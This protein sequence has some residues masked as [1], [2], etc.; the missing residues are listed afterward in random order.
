MRAQTDQTSPDETIPLKPTRSCDIVM[1]G[2]V[3]S[4]IVYPLTV[5]ELAR[6]YRFVNVGGASAGAI[7]ASLTAA[8]EYRRRNGDAR[9]FS[10]DLMNLPGLLGSSQ[11]GGKSLLFSLF[12]PTA[13]TRATYDCLIGFLETKSLIGKSLWGLRGLFRMAP[14]AAA[15]GSILWLLG[16]FAMWTVS[17]GW[18]FPLA[19]PMLLLVSLL[20]VAVTA[21]VVISCV[22]Q[23]ASAIVK[24][25]Y[26][27]CS[28]FIPNRKD[29]TPKPLTEWLADYLDEVAG[30]PDQ[31]AP[32]T[33]GDLWNLQPQA[34]DPSQTKSINLQMMTTNL[35]L[36]RP[37]QLPFEQADFFFSPEEFRSLFPR[38]IVDW[39]VAH[40][41][42]AGVSGYRSLPDSKH[43]PVVVATRM[44]LSFP[45]LVSAIPLYAVD[46]SHKKNEETTEKG[47]LERC[48]LSDG[49]ICS[50]FPVHFFDSPI[51]RWPTFAINLRPF[52]PDSPRDSNERKNVWMPRTNGEGVLEQWTRFHSP[53]GPGSLLE[54]LWAIID[55]MQNWMDNTQMKVPGYRDRVAHVY[56]AGDEGGLN[57][58]MNGGVMSRLSSRGRIA[59]ELLR[60]RFTGK[61]MDSE[62]D[63]DNHRWV[64]Y[65]S[66]MT[67]L[68]DYLHTVANRYGS[69]PPEGDRSY[70]ELV[71]RKKG[72]P[73]AGYPWERDQQA[74]AL[75]INQKILQ[76]VREWEAA[77]ESFEDGT[78]RPLPEL[79]IRPRM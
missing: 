3:T 53:S 43:L 13:S 79:R 46:R 40:S 63:W 27:L 77:D 75:E 54:F 26:G 17:Q 15:M 41:E 19:G 61:D 31:K 12:Q 49:G 34:V 68:E 64:R 11:S 74:F 24:N 66:T 28:G 69:L 51:P 38:R 67:L 10:E 30:K 20:L 48:W 78:P 16:C 72:S 14:I 9:G 73:P 52:H 36:G 47:D 35:T 23:A 59:G 8:A 56:L 33:F 58:N 4:G 5:C 55:T 45:L 62:L 2:G 39:M 22:R 70:A 29:G 65:R 50:N 1:K 60:R 7:A 32:L 76:L 18:G 25:G 37:Y 21:G 44:S 57:L 6:D 42:P 71:S